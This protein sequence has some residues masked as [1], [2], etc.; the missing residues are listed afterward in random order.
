MTPSL[1]RGKRTVT[2]TYDDFERMCLCHNLEEID[3]QAFWRMA[4]RLQKGKAL[5]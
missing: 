1:S 4:L 2:L 3:A 5:S